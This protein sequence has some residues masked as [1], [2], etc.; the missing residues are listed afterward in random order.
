MA[1][2][3]DLV[4]EVTPKFN[5]DIAR[6][7]AMK[8]VAEGE[9]YVKSV[10]AAA[11]GSLPPEIEYVG[12]APIT[13]KE[14]FEVLL[15]ENRGGKNGGSKQSYEYARSTI[16]LAKFMFRLRGEMIE[17]QYI[18]LP[19]LNDGALMKI[20]GSLYSVAPQ[21]ADVAVSVTSNEIYVPVTRDKLKHYRSTHAI[22]Y[23]GLTTIGH[24][25]W[26]NLYRDSRRDV[27]NANKTVV[28][29]TTVVHYLLSKFGLTETARKM[30][31]GEFSVGDNDEERVNFLRDGYHVFESSRQPPRGLKYQSEPS[32]IWFAFSPKEYK[33]STS[34]DFIA[35]V[36]YVIDHFPD[37]IT[38]NELDNPTRWLVLLAHAIFANGEKET[39]LLELVRNHIN[40]IE[41]YVDAKSREWFEQGDIGHVKDIYD[42]M[43]EMANT[44]TRR[45][46]EAAK[47]ST[48]MYGKHLLVNRKIYSDV[49]SGIFTCIYKLQ[50]MV[51]SRGDLFSKKELETELKKRLNSR[52]ILQLNQ[53]RHP[54]VEPVSCPGAYMA[55]KVTTRLVLQTNVSNSS[56]AAKTIFDPFT[57]GNDV[58]IAECGTMLAPTKGEAT[59]RGQ[60]NLFTLIEPRTG[61]V[62]Q[63]EYLRHITDPTQ[64]ALKRN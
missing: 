45:R 46:L 9:E 14:A 32:K 47:T 24:V 8:E 37:R 28:M 57:M 6:G 59:G 12:S 5:E 41:H 27:S 50:Q 31:V 18:G 48:S 19:F 23:N 25:V 2:L 62:L 56:K 13:T 3:I 22:R 49:V 52:V 16:Y 38:I 17:P 7:Y 1:R 43:I 61:K 40:S 33:D 53:S 60:F 44:Y 29:N 11:S 15:G 21:L 30:G 36:Y 39:K 20:T 55:Y 51:R 54:E 34:R 35:S 26:S 42:L 64:E 63:K 4:R 10:L 58:S